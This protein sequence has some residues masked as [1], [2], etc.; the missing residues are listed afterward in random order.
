MQ[1]M[2]KMNAALIAHNL[3]LQTSESYLRGNYVDS[4][5]K[6]NEN[7]TFIQLSKSRM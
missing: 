4:L 2:K 1:Q 3:Q 6:L 5:R 7:Q